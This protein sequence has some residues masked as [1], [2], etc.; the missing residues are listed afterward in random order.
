MG[1][2]LHPDQPDEFMQALGPI[3][4]AGTTV[5][6]GSWFVEKGFSAVNAE[7][8]V[9]ILKCPI[10][11]QTSVTLGGGYQSVFDIRGQY[12]DRY[13]DTTRTLEEAIADLRTALYKMARNIRLIPDL[14]FDGKVQAMNNIRILVSSATQD[15]GLGFPL[16]PGEIQIEVQG[17]W[18]LPVE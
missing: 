16:I 17:P 18:F 13:E 5:G 11:R 14:G 15:I 12:L 1:E 7:F 3:M 2:A 9:L 10:T 8:P 4:I 6:A